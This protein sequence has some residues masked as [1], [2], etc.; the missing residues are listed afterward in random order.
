MATLTAYIMVH[1][2]CRKEVHAWT[3]LTCLS[4]A[5]QILTRLHPKK[6]E[7]ELSAAMHA[8]C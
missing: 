6:Y 7:Q 2:C 3:H 5:A 8:Q 1:S 4:S